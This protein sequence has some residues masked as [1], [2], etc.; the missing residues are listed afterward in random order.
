MTA[1]EMRVAEFNAKV[2]K[3]VYSKGEELLDKR[4]RKE[5]PKPSFNQY[6]DT[7]EQL[8]KDAYEYEGSTDLGKLSPEEIYYLLVEYYSI[9]IANEELKYYEGERVA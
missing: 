6:Y 3:P 5:F 9:D 7:E 1:Y 2:N 4:I 8:A